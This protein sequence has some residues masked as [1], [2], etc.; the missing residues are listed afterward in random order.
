[1]SVSDRI[2]VM[3]RGHIEQI[4]TP[5]EIY[6]HPAS[7]FVA[8]FVGQSSSF[9]A[10]TEPNVM[11][12]AKDLE[13]RAN[14]AAGFSTGARVRA[15]IRPEDVLLGRD[16]EGQPDAH[17]AR[18]ASLE[19][20]GAV[21]RLTLECGGMNIDADL[22]ADRVHV[23]HATEGFRLPMRVPAERILLFAADA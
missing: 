5:E 10:V 8:N 6:R 23:E 7:A 14:G 4:G 18:V 1:M 17:P 13:L 12:K 16:A 11:I 3:S 22:A 9:D 21:V 19:F 2:V 20:R 15:F